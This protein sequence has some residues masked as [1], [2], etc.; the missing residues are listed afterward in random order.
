MTKLT[1]LTINQALEGLKSNQ[2]SCTELL[3]EHVAAMEKHRDMNLFITETLDTARKQATAS[4]EKYSSGKAGQLEGIPLAIKDIFCTTGVKTT[5]GSH[6]LHNFVPQYDSTVTEKLFAEGAVMLGKANMDEFAMGSA[7]TYSHFGP[8]INPWK[9][10][11]SNERFVPGGSSGGS[12]AAVAARI[13]M[14][15]TGTDTGGS[16]RQPAAFCGIVGFKPSYGR[17]SRYGII[18]FS[19]SLDQAGVFARNVEDTALLAINSMGYDP[20]DSTSSDIPL[21]DLT[22]AMK[23]DVKGMRIGIPKEY[24]CEGLDKEAEQLWN[25]SVEA[26]KKEGAEIK[27]ISLPHTKYGIAAYYVIAPAEGSSNY[28]RYDGVR[29]GLREYKEGMSLDEMYAAT[30]TSGFGHEAQR[31]IMIGTYVLSSGYY[32]D[33]FLK[34]QRVRRLLANDFEN[35]FKDVD[36][37]ITPTA[38]TPAFSLDNKDQLDPIALYLND[39]FTIPASMAGL[40]AIS[41]PG[42]LNSK[43][44]PLGV[45]II[46]NRFDEE[47]VFTTAK[48]LERCFNFKESPEGF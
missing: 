26:L 17:C 15:S 31:R 48:N 19:S 10:K 20:K 37:I 3:N 29:Y 45:Q 44:M 33:Y 18:S 35:A 1:S 25:D 16:V 4:D 30:R 8:A 41:I 40:P 13:A 23:K 27:E 46:G 11:G 43:G 5:N 21:P 22:S 47:A 28:S 32:D 24:H 38:P 42:R 12:A 36:A 7:N 14:G 39:L 2:F 6:I 9:E 34:A